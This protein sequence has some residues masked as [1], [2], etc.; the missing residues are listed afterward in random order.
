M[1]NHSIKRFNRQI[2][3]AL[4]SVFSILPI[5]SVVQVHGSCVCGAVRYRISVESPDDGRTTLCHCSSCRKAFGTNFGLTTKVRVLYLS[6]NQSTRLTCAGSTQLFPVRPRDCSKVHARQRCDT[7]ILQYVRRLYMRIWG[8]DRSASNTS[9]WLNCHQEQ[10][11]DKFRYVMWGTM[12][13]PDTFPPKGEFFCKNRA[14][15]MPEISGMISLL[16][17]SALFSD[18]TRG[19]FH[20]AEIHD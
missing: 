20:K 10:A 2:V 19:V 11:T 12:S 17:Q 3:C 8:N 6:P 1:A 5:M 14:K 16:K 4:T 9:S 13:E 7:R 18:R 15:W